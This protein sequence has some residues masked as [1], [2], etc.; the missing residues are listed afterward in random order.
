MP[1]DQQEMVDIGSIQWNRLEYIRMVIHLSWIIRNTTE[2]VSER[3][4][5]ILP[6]SGNFCQSQDMCIFRCR[7]LREFSKDSLSLY[8]H[9][10]FLE[11]TPLHLQLSVAVSSGDIPFPKRW[12]LIIK[13]EEVDNTEHDGIISSHERKFPR[14]STRHWLVKK[15]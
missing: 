2:E 12:N 1:F 11:H 15:Q 7:I 8:F 10:S 13:S 6:D 5:K 3:K 14:K 9:P 4:E